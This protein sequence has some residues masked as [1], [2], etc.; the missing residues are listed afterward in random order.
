M[1]KGEMNNLVPVAVKQLKLAKKEH[2]DDL[3]YA[4]LLGVGRRRSLTLCCANS[5][6]ETMMLI[7]VHPN[8]NLLFGI[9][10]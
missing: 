1:F 5:E 8:I 3:G 2:Q 6:H 10:R 4:T 9:V 7:S